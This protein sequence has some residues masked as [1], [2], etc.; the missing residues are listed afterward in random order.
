MQRGGH[1]VAGHMLK[2]AASILLFIL[3]FVSLA[4][5]YGCSGD[6]SSSKASTVLGTENI[7]GK[8]KIAKLVGSQIPIAN[9]LGDQQNP[10]VI[11]LPNKDLWFTVYEDWGNLSSGSD[12]KGRFLK[13]DGTF[14]GSEV[15]ITNAQGNQTTPWAAYR[16]KD[17]LASPATGHDSIVVVWE[18][19]RGT[20]SGGYVYYK[21]INVDSFAS[22][23]NVCSVSPSMIGSETAISYNQITKH[24]PVQAGETIGSGNGSTNSFHT[25]LQHTPI[26][27]GSVTVTAGSVT[28]TDNSSGGFTGSACASGTSTIN[29]TTGDITINF[30]S[31]SCIPASGVLISASYSYTVPVSAETI[32]FG[33]GTAKSFTTLAL[34][35]TPIKPLSVSITTVPASVTLTD[36]GSG[37]LTGGGAVVFGTVNY[38]TGAVNLTFSSAPAFGTLINADYTYTVTVPTTFSFSTAL[39]GDTLTSRKSPRIA[40]DPVRDRFW[41]VWKESRSTLQRISEICFGLAIAAW[42]FGD[43]SSFPGYVMLD[44]SKVFDNPTLAELPNSI[45]INGADIIRNGLVRTNRLIS[46]GLAALTETYDYEFFTGLNNITDATDITEPETFMAWEGQRQKGE[47]VCTCTDKNGNSACDPGEP[48]TSTFKVTPFDDGFNHI[49]GLFDK[50]ISKTSV[51]SKRLDTSNAATAYFPA[52]GFDPITK[53]FLAAWE[54]MRDGL[55]KKIWGQLVYSGGGLYNINFLISFQDTDGDGKQDPNIANSKQTR[56]FISYDSVNQRYFV[57]W[58]D[59]RNGTVSLENLD[60]FGQYVD[61]EGSLRG[62]NYAITTAPSNQLS[63]AIAYNSKE[64]LFL[65]VWKDAQNNSIPFEGSDIYGQ[66]FS[67]GQ[68][69]L[70]LLNLDDTP[71]SPPLLNFGS[72]TVG[73]SSTKSFKIRNTGDTNLKIFC[74]SQLNAPFSYATP[75][76]SALQT[77][78]TNTPP[79]PV[80]PDTNGSSL[81]IIPGAELTFTVQFAPSSQDTSVSNFTIYSD[82]ENQTV[83]LQGGGVSPSMKV[84]SNNIDFGNVRVGQSADRPLRITNNGTASYQITNITIDNA[85]F[86]IVSPP[87]FPL[88]LNA[89][90]FLDLT[91]RFTPTQS[92]GFGSQM[93]VQTNIQGLG[94][95]IQLSANGTAPLLSV[96]TTSLDYGAVTVGTNSNQNINLSNTGNETLTVNSLSVPGSSGFSVVG[97]TLP[98]N[99]SAGASQTIT[100]RFSPTD[101]TSYSS[102]L[103]IQSNGGTQ[104]VS[105]AGQGAGGKITLSPAQ[106]DFQTVAVGASKTVAITVSNTGNA[107]MNITGI[108]IPSAP[109]SLIF[110]GTPTIQLLPGTSYTVLA[111]FS[112]TTAGTFN[113]SF[114]INTNAINGNQTVNL[115]GAAVVPNVIITPSSVV[116]PDTAVNQIQS[117]NISIKN[118]SPIPVKINAFS[119]PQSASFG[120]LFQVFNMSSGSPVLLNATDTFT[121]QPGTTLNF[122]ITFQPPQTGTFNSTFGILFDFALSPTYVTISGT[123]SASMSVTPAGGVLDFGTVKVGTT[124]NLGVTVANT[125]KSTFNTQLIGLTS[126]FTV[127]STIDSVSPGQQATATI[128]FVPL[129]RGTYQQT[130]TIN[131]DQQG[132]SSTI[133]V[134]GQAV[135]PILRVE[136]PSVDF[137]SVTVGSTV[138]QNITLFNDGDGDMNVTSCGSPPDGFSISTCPSTIPTGAN[139]NLTIT[140]KP[141]DAIVNSGTM[142]IQTDGGTKTVTLTGTGQGGKISLS[143][144]QIDFGAVAV[145]TSNPVALTVTNTGNA[146][147]NITDITGITKDPASLFSV[148]FNGTVPIQL[149]PN[150][151]F[152]ITVLFKPTTAANYGSSFVI[153]TDGI[154]GNKTVNL[155]GA[156]IAP[157]VSVTPSPIVFDNTGIG[158][159]QSVNLAIKNSGTLSVTINSFDSPIAPFTIINLPTT[160]FSLN[161]GATL[162][163]VVKFAPTT[164]GTFS[165]SLGILF[166]FA[167]TPTLVNMTGT[168]SN[169]AANIIFQQ[170][171]SQITSVGFGN[172]LKGTT[173]T[174]TLSVKNSGSAAITI[175]TGALSSSAFRTTLSAPFT[176]NSGET[177]VFDVIFNPTSVASFSDTLTLT[178]ASGNTYQLSLTGAGSSIS[179]SS[180]SGTV[181]FF[182]ALTS[183]QLPTSSKP[184]NFNISRAATFVIEGLNPNSSVNVSITFDSLPASP[185]FYKVVGTTWTKLTDYNLQGNVLTFSITDNGP[186]DSDPTPGKIQ[187]PIVAGST[188]GG[189]GGGGSIHNSGGGGC[190]I[191]TA[192]YGSYLD[193]HVMVLREFR[194]K[195]LLTNA[196]GKTFVALY[197][198]YS[199]PVADFI[200]QHEMLRTATRFV[201]TPIVYGVKYPLPAMGLLFFSISFFGIRKRRRDS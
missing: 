137:G 127:F 19:P 74:L 27:P 109:F 7:D 192:A 3:C 36:N 22:N 93:S 168:S 58:E 56:P 15:T 171:G 20:G 100:V 132:L 61:T 160:P 88:T 68:P 128:R 95:T 158:A 169:Q 97:A 11:Y 181:S 198:K 197:Y 129:A 77:I 98:I 47:M 33:D 105:L 118:N 38:S 80:G 40:Y 176:L 147:L 200:R 185:V 184:S 177:K 201:L 155:Q 183:S 199:P 32:G 73:Q 165:S 65:A 178:D 24:V 146:P 62:T 150:T 103:S 46:A 143:Q 91:L 59:G 57:A 173:S 145:N 85:L 71:L 83:N 87:T 96:S 157:D 193:A 142:D 5:L 8:V 10:H 125:G 94:Q 156:G 119:L 121:L 188:T 16:E 123:S 89:G 144:E 67:L 195:Y 42:E 1:K 138:T 161:A 51:V 164:A 35:H 54:D 76:P 134:K 78:C 131:T 196:P 12:I 28:L 37:S 175:N 2:Q 13:K 113:G 31:G 102:A 55:T 115:Q 114:I 49:Y 106:V 64:N 99:I 43:N 182:T 66:R 79:P 112:P 14:C 170:G 186:F 86:S 120:T 163:L 124:K 30:L 39:L 52:L 48:I 70:T 53:R 60:I 126:P 110:T 90:Q 72:V 179:I 122:V 41:V 69:Q 116:F 167:V 34:Q 6:T 159:T 140:F 82:G 108:T 149:L 29:Y 139:A 17:I 172:V 25:V 190:F 21:T 133:T 104:T 9:G 117:T 107:P 141:T 187:D 45:G 18:D 50:E 92:G 152:T 44:G 174:K 63:P 26:K 162:N 23:E 191:A 111:V 4:G 130:L 151:K 180:D 189:G 154:N 75:L 153:H 194:D 84:S 148:N 166:D 81:S 101:I 136:P 135:A